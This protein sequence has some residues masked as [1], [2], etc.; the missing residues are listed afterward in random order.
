MKFKTT[1]LVTL[2][3]LCCSVSAQNQSEVDRSTGDSIEFIPN[4]GQFAD[5]KGK[6]R[7]DIL[8]LSH[9]GPIEIYLRNKGI[10]Y[11]INT[12][13]NPHLI[14]GFNDDDPHFCAACAIFS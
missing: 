8:Y 13:K 7:N 14:P 11:V 10:S 1:L 6:V 9:A 5:E 2:I 3:L 4:K 12:L